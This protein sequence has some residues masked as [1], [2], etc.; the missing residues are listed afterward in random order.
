MMRV[1][2]G[3]SDRNNCTSC[4]DPIDRFRQFANK[5]SVAFESSFSLLKSDNC[6]DLLVIA[7]RNTE[8]FQPTEFDSPPSISDRE[9]AL[10]EEDEEYGGRGEIPLFSHQVS[11]YVT[12]T[13]IIVKRPE[14]TEG[15]TRSIRR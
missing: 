10:K 4:R 8:L 6:S 9:T 12:I 13:A 5:Q 1:V 15:M 3:K 11:D 7:I 14:T 2:K